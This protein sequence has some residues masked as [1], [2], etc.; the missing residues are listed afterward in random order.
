MIK[1]GIGGGN[2]QTGIHFEGKVDIVTYLNEN[3]DGYN[4]I[5]KPYNNKNQTMGFDI[6]YDDKLIAESF[7]KHELYR[8]L[9]SVGIDSSKILSNIDFHGKQMPQKSRMVQ[10]CKSNFFIFQ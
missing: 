7:K 4:C 9:S 6:N 2:T 1:G 10:T 3:V 5:A 8:Y